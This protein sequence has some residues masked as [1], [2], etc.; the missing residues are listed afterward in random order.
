MNLIGWN[1][2]NAMDEKGMMRYN[3]GDEI[4]CLRVKDVLDT[5]VTEAYSF[6]NPYIRIEDFAYHNNPPNLKRDLWRKEWLN[7]IAD[8]YNGQRMMGLEKREAELAT[9]RN[10]FY[11]VILRKNQ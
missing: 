6:G 7:Y 3:T 10:T 11:Y 2:G 8:E 9:V 1:G 5:L 4:E